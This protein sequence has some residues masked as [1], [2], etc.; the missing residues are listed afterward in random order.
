MKKHLVLIAFAM[1]GTMAFAQEEERGREKARH[2]HHVADE[3]KKQLSLS[4]DQ[5][6]KIG[7]IEK[8]YQAKFHDLRIDS[9]RSKED[10]INAMKLLGE[11]R[12]K[13]VDAVLTPEQLSKWNVQQTAR[14]DERRAHSE[15][16]SNDRALKM[17]E[18]LSMND[19]QFAKFQK[20][21]D[22]FRKSAKELRDKTVNG[23]TITEE[24][25]KNDFKKIREA[26]DK[27]MKS[28][29]NKEQYRKWNEMKREHHGHRGKGK[30]G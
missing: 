6:A 11:S 26:Y 14:H 30:M 23:K 16:A 4:D 10:K 29:L 7:V 12:K 9:T 2:H 27:E 21:N 3:M 20:A 13:E 1:V 18:D 8:S 28:I 22:E 15:K 25:R 5:Y 17:K 24:Q 19:K